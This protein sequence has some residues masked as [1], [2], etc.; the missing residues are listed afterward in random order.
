MLFYD[1]FAVLKLGLKRKYLIMTQP[2]LLDKAS[3]L[4]VE[5]LNPPIGCTL[6]D[7]CAAPGMKTCQ[8]L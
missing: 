1:Q 2:F 6:L 3:C 5:A 8:G 7:S 4:S